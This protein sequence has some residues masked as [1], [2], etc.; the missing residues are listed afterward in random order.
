[1]TGD[2]EGARR[3]GPSRSRSRLALEASLVFVLAA[4]IRAAG[5][6]EEALHDE[7]YNY[8]AAK[9]QLAHGTLALVTGG[10]PYM[11]GALFTHVVA[12]CMALF[13]DALWVARLP[14][15]VAGSLVAMLTFVWTAAVANRWAG[16]TAAILV[17]VDPLLVQL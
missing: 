14:A 6:G 3:A 8:L 15:L 11:R 5:L 2:S 17:C 10:A 16:W 4:A 9:N 7:L 13:G 12:Q 1:M